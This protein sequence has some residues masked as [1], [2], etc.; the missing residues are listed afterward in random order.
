MHVCG[1]QPL[2]PPH[3]PAT[4]PPPHVC[5]GAHVPQLAMTPP[6][7]SPAGPHITLAGHACG[8]HMPDGGVQHCPETP[9]PPHVWPDGHG[10]QSGVRPP[11]PSAWTPQVFGYAAQVSGTQPVPPPGVPQTPDVPPPPHVWPVGQVQVVVT[12][13]HPSLC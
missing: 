6:Q 11:Q 9:Q 8:V 13:P 10:L 7:P 2:I 3:C 12:P 5:G 4:P 1:T